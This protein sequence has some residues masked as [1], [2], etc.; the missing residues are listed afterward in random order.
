MKYLVRV[1]VLTLCLTLVFGTT[2]CGSKD[3]TPPTISNIRAS[4]VKSDSAAV[5]WSTDE[6]STTESE[7][8]QTTSYQLYS[9]LDSTLKTTHVVYLTDLKSGTTYHYRV[10]SKDGSGNEAISGDYTFTTAIE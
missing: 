5:V 6:K 1:L 10:K 8:G 2:G 7:L 4:S 3:T 9:Y